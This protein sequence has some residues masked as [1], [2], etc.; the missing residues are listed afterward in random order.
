M[1]NYSVGKRLHTIGGPTVSAGMW[2][3]S[4]SNWWEAG[5]ATGCVVAYQPKGAASYAASKSNLANPGTLDAAEVGGALD[6]DAAGWSGFASLSRCID[7]GTV[8]QYNWSFIVR[9]ASVTTNNTV[10]CGAYE[11][12]L[13]GAYIA[14]FTAGLSPFLRG[15]G[16]TI[17]PAMATGVY[18]VAGGQAYR[19][20]TA[21]G[22][23]WLASSLGG[24]TSRTMYVGAQHHT[25]A[26][27]YID[28]SIQA[29]AM[30]NNVL[31]ATKMAA[32]SAAMAAL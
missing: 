26:T 19:N 8:P 10:V 23:S 29:F 18:G 2:P 27:Q 16:E 32:V 22:S 13:K 30:F 7:A 21:D 5:G 28:G 9:Y 12:G 6:W 3:S 17:A 31:D 1:L 4:A 24:D 15:G 25:A 14:Y 20:G 11:S